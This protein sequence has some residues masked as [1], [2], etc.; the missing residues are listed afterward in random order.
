MLKLSGV[1]SPFTVL[2][3]GRDASIYIPVSLPS[4]D[5]VSGKATPLNFSKRT[6]IYTIDTGE[7]YIL[8]ISKVQYLLNYSINIFE[9]RK[10][11]NRG[12]I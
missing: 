5:T 12:N 4:I 3:D 8:N 9:A 6:I 2:I 7:I 10:L 11:L 1:A